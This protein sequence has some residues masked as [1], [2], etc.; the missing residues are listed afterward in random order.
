[1]PNN[2][3]DST[4]GDETNYRF[5]FLAALSLIRQTKKP[6]ATQFESSKL[7]LSRSADVM[8]LKLA[9]ETSTDGW[10]AYY[11][12]EKCFRLERKRNVVKLVV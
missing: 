9:E 5:T 7:L 1:L 6:N 2:Y 10:V 12:M 3:D 4:T 11:Q 8:K